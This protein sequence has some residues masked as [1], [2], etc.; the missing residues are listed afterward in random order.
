[1]IEETSFLSPV[2]NLS[3]GEGPIA[4]VFADCINELHAEMQ[5]KTGLAKLQD[6][7]INW[8]PSQG[9]VILSGFLM[10]HETSVTW[11]LHGHQSVTSSKR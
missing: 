4:P 8:V 10:K 3:Q 6:Y 11:M 1:M 7:I 9:Y 2:L 5:K